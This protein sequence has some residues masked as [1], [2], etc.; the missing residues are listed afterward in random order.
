MSIQ[1]AQVSQ[2]VEKLARLRNEKGLSQR[3]LAA[4]TGL[5]HSGISEMESGINSPTLHFLLLIAAALE[6]DLGLIIT[7]VCKDEKPTA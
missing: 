5:S 1:E 7:E 4:R 6:V 2:V 3:E